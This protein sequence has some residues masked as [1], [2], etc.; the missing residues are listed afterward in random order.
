MNLPWRAFDYMK[1]SQKGYDEHF[2]E[3]FKLA[4]EAFV[5]RN[6]K[7][8]INAGAFSPRGLA[9]QVERVLAN[10]GDKGKAKIVA[11]IE[12]DNVE[13]QCQNHP[14]KIRHLHNG[15]TLK[16]WKLKAVTS[17]VYLGAWGI[18]RALQEGADIVICGRVTDASPVMGLAAWWHNWKQDEA[19]KMAQALAAGHIL[20]CGTY[21]VSIF[22]R[23]NWAMKTFDDYDCSDRGEFPRI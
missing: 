4:A 8:V 3:S 11:W 12:G 10:Y 17:N 16:E 22:P 5:S 13:A 7:L 23:H 21:V 2:L 20:E 15:S 1:D 18:V 9:V 19:E 14:E 6:V